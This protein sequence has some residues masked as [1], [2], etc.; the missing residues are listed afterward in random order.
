MIVDS[1]TLQEV[2]TWL[3][4]HVPSDNTILSYTEKTFFRACRKNKFEDGHIFNTVYKK[5]VENVTYLITF[6]YNKKGESVGSVVF[7]MFEYNR[8]INIVSLNR[9]K[10]LMWYTRHFRERVVERVGK[11]Q[12]YSTNDF[13]RYATKL[14]MFNTRRQ[15]GGVYKEDICYEYDSGIVIIDNKTPNILFHITFIQN[16]SDRGLIK[17]LLKSEINKIL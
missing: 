17:R 8:S 11:N 4:D 14:A 13:L 3:F 5:T 16:V 10:R 7:A 9:D 2:R 12:V 6:S 1:M 15:D